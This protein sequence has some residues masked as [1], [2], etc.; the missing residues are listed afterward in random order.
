MKNSNTIEQQAARRIVRS[1]IAFAFGLAGTVA[2]PYAAQVGSITPPPV[3]SDIQVEAGHEVFL[4]GR[5]VGTQ[6]YVCQPANSIG[7]VAWTLF[8]PQATLFGGEGEQ[9]TTHFFSP[10]PFEPSPN[11]FEAGVV[12]AAWQDSQDTSAVWGRV[13]QPSSDPDFVAPRSIPWLL[14]AAVGTQA[15]PTGSNRFSKTTFIQRLNTAGGVAPST[16]CRVPTDIGR[17][18]FVPYAAD[19]FFYR[20]N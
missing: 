16:G 9:L 2:M 12:R 6:N 10:N 14:I 17:T 19:Y 20:K 1:L 11:P 15:G 4:L 18:A 7:R 3:P 8:T 5:G 13:V